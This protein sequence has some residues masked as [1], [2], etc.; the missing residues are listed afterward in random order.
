MPTLVE[1]KPF[2]SGAKVRPTATAHCPMTTS[3]FG[4]AV[5]TGRSFA[6]ILSNVTKRVASVATTLATVRGRPGM[7]TKMSVGLLAKLKELVM[8]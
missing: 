7:V 2:G 4:T 8:T 5:G 1:G 3:F 6:S